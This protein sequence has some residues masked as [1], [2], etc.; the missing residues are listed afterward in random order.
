M[1][2]SNGRTC[3]LE[4]VCSHCGVVQSILVNPED[5][6]K[7]QSGAYVQDAFPYLSAGEREMIISHT[8]DTCWNNMFGQSEEE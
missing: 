8:C 5:I 4:L 1:I 7:Y 2:C 6:L 3:N